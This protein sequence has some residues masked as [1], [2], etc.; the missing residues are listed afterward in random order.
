MNTF[1]N[2]K[3]YLYQNF[4]NPK[5]ANEVSSLIAGINGG[6][7]ISF[8]SSDLPGTF[9]E[10]RTIRAT[11][12]LLK[13][14]PVP[15]LSRRSENS[16]AYNQYSCHPPTID[17]GS[18]LDATKNKLIPIV[19]WFLD[20]FPFIARM[21]AEISS[22]RSKIIKKLGLACLLPKFI[23]PVN[24]FIEHVKCSLGLDNKELVE[25]QQCS[26][27]LCSNS[28]LYDRKMN[29]DQRF[30]NLEFRVKDTGS[31]VDECFEEM[32]TETYGARVIVKLVDDQ[33]CEDPRFESICRET[34]SK[35]YVIFESD[36]QTPRYASTF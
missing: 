3:I 11:A 30:T 18:K 24:P 15:T 29:R 12:T 19:T 14:P 1:I 26:D 28:V 27:N 7:T 16:N 36:C 34:I 23:R 17:I 9:S 33:P 21:F 5:V 2:K 13:E 4:Q 8:F 6:A 20:L 22:L 25:T 31:R 35:G 10:A 32:E